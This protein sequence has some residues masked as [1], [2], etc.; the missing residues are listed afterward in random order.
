ML[1]VLSPI[2]K[3]ICDL[4]AV[5]VLEPGQSL[6]D[7]FVGHDPSLRL[8]PELVP[9]HLPA[10]GAL[11]IRAPALRVLVLCHNSNAGKMELVMT[12]LQ[13][14]NS[15]IGTSSTLTW[16]SRRGLKTVTTNEADFSGLAAI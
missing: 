8:V 16:I 13:R 9:Q 2:L 6:G 7:H 4:Y 14:N 10:T 5:V 1:T 12:L 15:V 3:I 11:D